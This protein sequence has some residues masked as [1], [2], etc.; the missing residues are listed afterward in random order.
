MSAT[1]QAIG[2]T[3]PLA[4]L[5]TLTLP[6][7]SAGPKQLLVKTLA[8]GFT[9]LT[10]WQVDFGLLVPDNGFILGGNLVGEVLEVGAEL[11]ERSDVKVGDKVF[12]FQFANTQSRP[13]QEKVII[14]EGLYGV[15]PPNLSIEEAVTIPDSF[16]TAVHSFATEL[17]LPISL[18]LPARTPPAQKDVEILIWGGGTSVGLFAVQLLRA[19]GYENIVVTASPGRFETLKAFGATQ[20]Y[21]Y[22]KPLPSSLKPEYVLDCVGDEEYSVKPIAALDLPSRAKVA[23]LLPV[24]IGGY[25]STSAVKMDVET[26][27]PEGV[28]VFGVRTHFYQKNAALAIDLQHS[29]MP[30]L[31]AEG[32]IKPTAYRVIEGATFLEKS[33]KALSEVREGKVRGEKLVILL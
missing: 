26:P 9:P 5:T 27:F 14:E 7:P 29:I 21:D 31:F 18:D 32:V 12:S 20:L 8:L 13:F 25:G 4:P 19:A 22:N 3:A 2:V 23:V 10:Q 1:H 33:V 16:V 17:S 6:T 15:L 24:R 11:A 30:K 28:Q